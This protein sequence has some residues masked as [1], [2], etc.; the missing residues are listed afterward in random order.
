MKKY[1]L[2]FLFY[3]SLDFSI[4]QDYN[5]LDYVPGII[6]AL[7]TDATDEHLMIGG[8]FNSSGDGEYEFAK[9]AVMENGWFINPE[10]GLPSDD[11]YG[12]KDFATSHGVV[13]AGSASDDPLW[14]LVK[15]DALG[16]WQ[17][18]DI[19]VNGTVYALD[20]L[21]NGDLLVVGD[22][23]SPFK[24][25][26]V[27]D[28]TNIYS[29]EGF[30]VGGTPTRAAN[31]NGKIYI[32]YLSMPQNYTNLFVWDESCGCEY[33]SEIYIPANFIISAIGKAQE[34]LY[35]CLWSFD[36]GFDQIY[37]STDGI[38]F[39]LIGTTDGDALGFT[40][41][42]SLVYIY[43]NITELNGETVN[44]VVT[45]DPMTGVWNSIAGESISGQGTVLGVTF[46]E[47]TM[48]AAIGAWIFSYDLEMPI[49]TTE[50]T[51]EI[52]VEEIEIIPLILYPNPAREWVTISE[53]ENVKY[54]NLYNMLGEKIHPDGVSKSTDKVT[55][56]VGNLPHGLY[57]IE[58]IDFSGQRSIGQ[59]LK[60]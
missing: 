32:A 19:S 59:L 37:E 38:S 12:I 9:Y 34:K 45:Y 3:L 18:L 6:Y 11:S 40:E 58:I 16:T 36:D 56:S 54:I 53:S 17:S 10:S 31:F 39:T 43:G 35:V 60:E 2:F 22:F 55:F 13:Y 15:Q 41:H 33:E 14:R 51:V 28:G 26:F 30:D 20:T 48:Y 25:A 1:I 50:D 47:N 24:G 21:S 7:T 8:S 29:L 5:K 49:D 27:Y 46:I 57:T 4:A 52:A 44:P 42:D 23:T